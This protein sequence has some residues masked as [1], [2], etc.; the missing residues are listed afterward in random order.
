[1]AP[2]GDSVPDDKDDFVK[3]IINV[4]VQLLGYDPTRRRDKAPCTTELE[5]LELFRTFAEG[6][7]TIGFV[8]EP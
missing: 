7:P 8:S 4:Q 1:L 3:A 5:E 2:D 6:M